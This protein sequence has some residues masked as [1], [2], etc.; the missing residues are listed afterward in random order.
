MSAYTVALPGPKT[1]AAA[2]ATTITGAI[3]PKQPDRRFLA[4][5][6]DAG[7]PDAR[8]TVRV[9]P[10][11]QVPS[12]AP[13]AFVV[14]G[15]RRPAKVRMGMTTFL[16]EHPDATFLVDPSVCDDVRSRVLS[17]MPTP[18]R[19]A[20]EPPRGI[21]AVRDMLT[22]VG[23]GPADIAFALPTHLHWDHVSGLLDL[24]GLEIKAH[25]IEWNWAMGTSV[26]PS[27]GVRASLVDRPVDTYE[28]DGPP[29]LTFTRSHD[30]LGDG[31]VLLVDLAGHSPGSVG[32]L[33]NTT[34]GPVLIAGDA[35]WHGTQIEDIRQKAG[36][37]GCLVDDD[38]RETFRT[39]HRLHAARHSATI[40][41][42]HDH[43]A[44]SAYAASG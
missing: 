44:T 2:V 15:R 12:E 35:A 39:L 19:K 38:R 3:R 13:R 26:A 5:I 21:V 8:T 23:L 1:Y 30:L 27:A 18:L 40:L 36:F 20:V 14:E 6:V 10:L 4:S 9:R 34:G 43:D 31:S 16:V 11:R 33:L 22:E 41:P 37:P 25:D 32:V 29:V 42:T 7:L 28:L 17:E 24:P